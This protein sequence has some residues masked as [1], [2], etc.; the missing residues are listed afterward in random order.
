MIDKLDLAKSI[1]LRMVEKNHEFEIDLPFTIAREFE[2]EAIKQ[3]L[4]IPEHCPACGNKITFADLSTQGSS[5]F[6]AIC[7]CGKA[8]G[9][10]QHE[11]AIKLYEAKNAG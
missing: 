11:A 7:L 2:K 1:L 9:L 10:S 3:G 4:C 8:S 5:Q 6:R